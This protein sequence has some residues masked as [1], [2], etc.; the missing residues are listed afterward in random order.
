MTIRRNQNALREADAPGFL[1]AAWARFFRFPSFADSPASVAVEI[2]PTILLDD[3]SN[4]P[5]PVYRPFTGSLNANGGAATWPEIQIVNADPDG[6]NSVLAI[7]WFLFITSG[8]SYISHG[9]LPP[10]S[11]GAGPVDGPFL[12]ANGMLFFDQGSEREGPPGANVNAPRL[13]NQGMWGHQVAAPRTLSENVNSTDFP[14]GDTNPHRIDG[15]WLLGPGSALYVL[16]ETQNIGLRL[17]V[18]G[19]YYPRTQNQ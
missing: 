18:R 15:P 14:N 10:N 1:S 9:I 16:T 11:G 17:Y 12:A 6:S 19:R 4:G 7:D 3:N 2:V 13:A 5:C 8:G